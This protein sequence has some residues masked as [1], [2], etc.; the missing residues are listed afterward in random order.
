MRRLEV[1]QF[2]D[3]AKIPPSSFSKYKPKFL[4][5]LCEKMSMKIDEV[6]KRIYSDIY[7]IKKFYK[8]SGRKFKLMINK[9]KSFFDADMKP[10]LLCFKDSKN[11]MD[12]DLSDFEMEEN[13]AEDNQDLD[14]EIS[15]NFI[16][17]SENSF[18]EYKNDEA[19]T[20][21][22]RIDIVKHL[23]NL[24]IPPTSEE[25]SKFFIEFLCEKLSLDI[26]KVPQGIHHDIYL[27]KRYFKKCQSNTDRMIKSHVTFFGADLKQ[28]YSTLKNNIE[29][30]N[31]I[32]EKIIPAIRRVEIVKH[33]D[34]LKIVPTAKEFSK[35]YIKYLCDKLSMKISEMPPKVYTSISDIKNFYKDSNYKVETMIKQHKNFFD[36]RI[37]KENL[38]SNSVNNDISVDDLERLPEKT[39]DFKE[40]P[41]LKR[42]EVVKY[43][44]DLN[45]S[46]N[47]D[48]YSKLYIDYLCQKFSLKNSEILN[49][50]YSHDI[51]MIKRYYKDCQFSI[52]RMIKKH[53]NF[54]EADLKQ[55]CLESIINEKTREMP[56]LHR[57]D[58]EEKDQSLQQPEP[59]MQPSEKN[60]E[61]EQQQKQFK[62]FISVKRLE[63]VN[64]LN[65]MKKQPKKGHF[66]EY[67]K[68]YTDYLC[69]KLSLESSDE[70]AK[71]VS[72]DLSKIKS[73]YK[74]YSYKFERMIEKNA[75]FFNGVY[76]N[77]THPKK[78][79]ENKNDKISS[80]EEEQTSHMIY[81]PQ[82]K[83]MKMCGKFI[84]IESGPNFQ[85]RKCENCETMTKTGKNHA[86]KRYDYFP[87]A[88]TIV[89]YIAKKTASTRSRNT[90]N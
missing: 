85:V 76:T 55:K 23:D 37:L 64:Y 56:I 42:L 5:Y 2:L 28:K 84:E 74:K 22:K 54:F 27:I 46:P 89:Q 68:L 31:D 21:L 11:D 41:S 12:P 90:P 43:L 65:D 79:T 20:S 14:P 53:Q 10:L 82:S 83:Q 86:L 38:I 33:L 75:T 47:R 15:Q 50:I 6:P 13:A 36:K 78:D 51:Y 45:I 9:H 87:L 81:S 16:G 80:S 62:K 60:Q 61:T 17:N 48:S 73:D 44:A 4:E 57:F 8:E 88:L 25:Y 66:L 69:K 70:L 18:P 35:F 19:I 1:V 77:I 39:G 7:K 30:N 59:E 58:S 29:L 3:E 63:V 67:S 72:F 49:G 26:D 52:D 34:D 71:K 32:D 40:I 24:K